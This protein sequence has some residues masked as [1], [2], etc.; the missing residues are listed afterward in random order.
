M[1]VH[2]LKADRR[3]VEKK[4]RKIVAP[5]AIREHNFLFFYLEKI[6]LSIHIVSLAP[7]IYITV[8]DPAF[9]PSPKHNNQKSTQTQHF[10][11]AIII[12]ETLLNLITAF[13]TS[14]SSK[15]THIRYACGAYIL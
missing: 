11:S 1:F 3:G 9:P 4:K 5:E 12:N 10:L 6:R 8:V 13:Y 14:Y 2:T 15:L 7:R